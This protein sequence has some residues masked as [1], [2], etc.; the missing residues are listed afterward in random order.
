MVVRS[1]LPWDFCFSSRALLAAAANLRRRFLMVGFPLRDLHWDGVT[2]AV[3]AL[4]S[5]TRGEFSE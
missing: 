4:M 3:A 1:V 5:T 2:P